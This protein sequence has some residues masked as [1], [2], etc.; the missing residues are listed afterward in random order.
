M[1]RLTNRER[2]ALELLSV[3]TPHGYAHFIADLGQGAG[4]GTL[5]SL[6]EKGLAEVAETRQRGVMGYRI[7]PAGQQC[8]Q[9]PKPW[10]W[11]PAE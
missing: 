8:V 9:S 11:P 2:R 10:T 7:T 4:V 6:G 5:E 1:T 3:P